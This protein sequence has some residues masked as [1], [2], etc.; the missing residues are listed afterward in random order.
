MYR[1]SETTQEN[2]Y[3][4]TTCCFLTYRH[5]ALF[6]R[7]ISFPIAHRIALDH[8]FPAKLVVSRATDKHLVVGLVTPPLDRTAQLHLTTR[9][10]PVRCGTTNNLLPDHYRLLL[11][12]KHMIALAS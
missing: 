4:T 6:Q 7:A 3:C 5:L 2:Y 1:W 8:I 11:Y 10:P 12:P 9:S